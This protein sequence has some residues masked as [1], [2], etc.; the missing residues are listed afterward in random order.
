MSI[1]KINFDFE[2]DVFTH[3]FTA[4]VNL[5]ILCTD[6]SKFTLNTS[7]CIDNSS[8]SQCKN[9]ENIKYICCCN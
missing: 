7:V 1:K 3:F 8:L 9:V 2:V 5:L 4:K 6:Y